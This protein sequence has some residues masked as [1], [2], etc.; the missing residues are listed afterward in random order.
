MAR[1]IIT[2]LDSFGIGS[3]HDAAA[4]GDAGSDTLGHIAA[5]MAANRKNADGSPRCLALPNL[6]AL[7]LET[8]H[9]LS[10]GVDLA[11]PLS[12]E[13][14]R[15]D[16]LDG[17]RVQAA[18]TCA[19]EVSKG[20]DTLS[21]HWEI[22]G[23]PVDFDWGYFPDQPKCFPQALVDAIIKEGNLPGVLGEKLASGTVIIQ[24]LGEEHRKTGK[25][26]IYSSADS[27]LQIACH[28]ETFGLERL[29]E[30]CKLSF[31]LVKPYKIARVIARP[32]V[33][34]RA[35]AF[36]RVAAHRHDYAVPAHE[37]TL[38][39]NLVAAGG[40]VYAVGKI[41]D[42][43]AHRG[44]TKH[45]PAAGLD[46]I[47]DATLLAVKDAPDQ[48]LVFSNFVDFD[49]S[50]GHRRDPLGYGEGLE[51][52]DG[53]LPELLALL[54]PEDVLLVTADHGCDPTWKGT[55]HTREKIPVLLYGSHVKPQQIPPFRI[56]SDI[57]Q[58]LAAH[59]KVKPLGH[60]TAADIWK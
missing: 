23:V 47:F 29:Y 55:D 10:T 12:G 53:R 41:A 58:T 40:S 44:I 56:F 20:K 28:E 24:E 7:G 31:E 21:G 59:L 27:V 16:V 46:R 33:G 42:I 5:W 11:Y 13:P 18:Y 30:L 6:A 2:L 37:A 1:V 22:A 60:G 15:D 34:N 14:L 51:Y 54:Q 3:A 49:S 25:P 39:D 38:L 48:T 57:G 45:Y 17:G 35:G 50:F 52:Y 4:F 19:E 32:F 43:F 36:E 8:A 9:K 26:I